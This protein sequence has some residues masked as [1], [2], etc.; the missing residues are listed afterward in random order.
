M[1]KI[2]EMIEGEKVMLWV[3][4]AL[5]QL[6]LLGLVEGEEEISVRGVAAWDQLDM[7]YRPSGENM[8]SCVEFL[9][10][11]LS[12]SKDDEELVLLLK[13]FGSDRDSLLKWWERWK[14]KKK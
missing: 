14:G 12:D 1:S 4:G 5:N 13:Q 10:R 3:L 8:A 2:D 6:R 11:D 9:N 7:V